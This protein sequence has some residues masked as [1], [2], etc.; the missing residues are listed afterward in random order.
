MEF[1]RRYIHFCKLY[2]SLFIFSFFRAARRTIAKI[3]RR[4]QKQKQN[5]N[6]QMIVLESQ[7]REKNTSCAPGRELFRAA[8]ARN[9]GFG[10]VVGRLRPQLG[11]PSDRFG[12]QNSVMTSWKGKIESILEIWKIRIKNSKTRDL[13]QRMEHACIEVIFIKIKEIKRSK[14]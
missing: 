5:A 4:F 11:P 3:L 1:S 8:P 2:S 6:Y 7:I 10:R 13:E 12:R 9:R 14:F